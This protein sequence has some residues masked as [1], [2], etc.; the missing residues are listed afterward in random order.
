MSSP[1]FA[2]AFG[3]LLEAM[4]IEYVHFGHTLPNQLPPTWNDRS[5]RVFQQNRSMFTRTFFDTIRGI[6]YNTAPQYINTLRNEGPVDPRI[7]DPSQRHTDR[8]HRLEDLRQVGLTLE[9][10]I[11]RLLPIRAARARPTTPPDA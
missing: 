10:V 7:T 8:N 9:D 6:V 11:Q 4:E 5:I 1:R 3:Q 2:Q